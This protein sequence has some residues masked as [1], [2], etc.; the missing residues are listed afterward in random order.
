MHLGS[1]DVVLLP[2][3]I[4]SATV[5]NFLLEKIIYHII[6]WNLLDIYAE[7]CTAH[8]LS[9]SQVLKIKYTVVAYTQN[10]QQDMGFQ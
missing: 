3:S 6:Y 4:V 9:Q 2:V 1:K 7:K 10:I 5:P 8:L